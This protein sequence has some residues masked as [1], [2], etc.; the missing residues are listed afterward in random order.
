[1]E[2][3]YQHHIL[4]VDGDD[5]TKKFIAALL[6]HEQINIVFADTGELGL[7][8]IKNA[9]APFSLIIS[10][11]GLNGMEG[12]LFLENSRVLAPDSIRFLMAV[13]SEMKTIINAVNQSDV[14]RFLVKPFDD[15]D[16]LKAVHAGL[17]LYHAFIEHERL[18][19]LAKQ[20]NSKLY[21]LNC[22]LLE[23][24]KAS[25]NTL[26]NLD[27][28]I[29]TL[30]D[31]LIDLSS[32]HPEDATALIEKITAHVKTQTGVDAGKVE[33]LFSETIRTL[34][35]QF[36]ELAQKNGL[37]MPQIEDNV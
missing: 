17:D 2:S 16:F 35:D 25:S 11:Q 24:A 21:E 7:E 34:Y 12:T 10:A 9:K 5:H 14:H 19:T 8:Q 36:D 30:N 4:V 37:V 32:G 26:H 15:T 33:T 18:L 13:Y 23:A 31:Q 22:Q 6:E 28:E 3:D 27:Q 20:Q 29:K 1:M